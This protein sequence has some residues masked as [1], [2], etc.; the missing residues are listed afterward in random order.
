MLYYAVRKTGWS[1]TVLPV[2]K[3]PIYI[4]FLVEIL[5]DVRGYERNIHDYML[6]AT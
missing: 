5:F 1:V 6:Q 3:C 2:L 4:R